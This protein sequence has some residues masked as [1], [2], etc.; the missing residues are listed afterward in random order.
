[1]STRANGKRTKHQALGD[2]LRQR[3][4]EGGQDIGCDE[5]MSFLTLRGWYQNG[6]SINLAKCEI[7]L[8]TSVI[9]DSR[10]IAELKELNQFSNA[11]LYSWTLLA[12]RLEG[13]WT[14]LVLFWLLSAN[15]EYGTMY[16]IIT[17]PV[18]RWSF[19][20]K[21]FEW[22]AENLAGTIVPSCNYCGFTF[23]GQKGGYH[24]HL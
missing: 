7:C 16:L 4:S 2:A 12:G 22:Q 15:L 8:I 17:R 6:E 1:M 20:F 24:L 14:L 21:I 19:W 9:I 13:S 10:M 3:S 23:D 5:L 11:G 18:C